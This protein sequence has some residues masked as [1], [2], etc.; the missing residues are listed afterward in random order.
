MEGGELAITVRADGSLH[1]QD[2]FSATPSVWSWTSR[3][4]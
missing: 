4:S 2:F 3:T 1:Y